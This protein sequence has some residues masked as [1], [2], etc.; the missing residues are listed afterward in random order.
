MNAS[1]GAN[2]T[3]RREF[4]KRSGRMATSSALV[5]GIVPRMYAAEGA[6]IKL[7]LV[8]CGGRGT[9]AVADAF[10]TTGG[11]VKLYAVADLFQDRTQSSLKNLKGGAC[12]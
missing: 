1:N 2:S 11:P 8:G 12:R 5:A 3:S 10:A 9:G 6:A 7:A 4:L